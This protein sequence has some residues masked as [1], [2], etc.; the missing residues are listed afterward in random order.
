MLYAMYSTVVAFCICCS[1][2]TEYNMFSPFEDS[3]LF[4]VYLFSVEVVVN[5]WLFFSDFFNSNVLQVYIANFLFWFFDEDDSKMSLVDL[6]VQ[7]DLLSTVVF[8]EAFTFSFFY[9]FFAVFFIVSFLYV[10]T[11]VVISPMSCFFFSTYGKSFFYTFA[12]SFY[13]SILFPYLGTA[14]NKYFSFFLFLFLFIL[15]SNVAG[16][17]PGFFAIT[18]NLTV[19]L[20]LSSV[21]WLGILFVGLYLHGTRFFASFFPAKVPFVLA[22]FL[23]FVELLSYLVRI[24]SLAVRLFANIVAGHILLD[25]ASLS[26]YY[27]WSVVAIDIS[28]STTFVSLLILFFLCVLIVF[29]CMIGLL[30]AYIFVIL[31]LIYLRDAIELH[32]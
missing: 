2:P 32:V 1:I 21:S 3:A 14:S 18:S 24:A 15:L 22:P 9:D 29:E 11:A 28:Y 4:S 17:I 5:A 6:L 25:T 12:A 16:L 13:N 8:L 10:V 26:F 23:M 27:I 31:S 7:Y 19:A 20:F 30:Q